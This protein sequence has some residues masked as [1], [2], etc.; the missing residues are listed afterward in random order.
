M[1]KANCQVFV[2]GCQPL[3][4]VSTDAGRLHG[5]LN[6]G[7]VSDHR[8]DADSDPGDEDGRLFSVVGATPAGHSK[9][10]L[11]SG[12]ATSDPGGL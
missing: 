11:T 3:C 5:G 8:G 2:R 7:I 6:P 10:L 4:E 9:S 12:E 1:L